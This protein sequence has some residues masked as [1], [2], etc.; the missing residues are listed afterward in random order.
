MDASGERG[1]P[2]ALN[3]AVAAA[4]APALAIVDSDD[5][6]GEGWLGAMGRALAVHP[7]VAA[8]IDFDRLNKGWVRES[9]F[10]IQRRGLERL[11]YLPHFVH[12]AGGSMGMQKTVTDRI[13]GFDGDFARLEDTEICVRAQIAGYDITFVPDAVI[14]YRARTDLRALFWQLYGWGYYEMKLVSR[15]RDFGSFAG[16]WWHYLRSWRRVLHNHL[17]K[18]LRPTPTTM[19]NAAWLRSE[20]GRLSGQLAGILRYRVPPDCPPR[21]AGN[22]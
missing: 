13:G 20:G 9:R 1:K 10:D 16:G 12:A 4:R 11:A 3:T 21:E 22:R 6:P 18:G 15:Y 2:F 17:R 8:R 19:R 7:I 5:V 14:H